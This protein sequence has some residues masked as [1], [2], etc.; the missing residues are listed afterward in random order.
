MSPELRLALVGKIGTG[1]SATGNTILGR[2]EFRTELSLSAI[3]KVCS[4]GSRT[5]NGR[6]L[7]VVD[8]PGLFDPELTLEQSI[9]EI[10]RCVVLSF[11][12]LHAI[13]Q[14]FSL[15][16]RLTEEEREAFHLINDIFGDEGTKYMII[17]FTRLDELK[18][19][20]LESY[21]H[22]NKTR[23]VEM[24]IDHCEGRFIAFNNKAPEEELKRQVSKLIDMVDD[25]VMK[26][27]E[28]C[29]SNKMF[30]KAEIE[31]REERKRMRKEIR[32]IHKKERKLLKAM[33]SRHLT[34]SDG[35]LR[36][37]REMGR[38]NIC[39]GLLKNCCII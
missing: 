27:G 14:V 13:I 29:Y 35:E 34:S 31:L 22:A 4:K 32:A 20:T 3:S 9:K 18:G 5:W 2:E 28:T 25:L 21:L 7:V 17:L 23:D 15:T 37:V 12:G 38:E 24:L 39:M 30:I 36:E 33:E 6:K 16:S 10:G 26:N 8:T 11:P 19:R 1:K